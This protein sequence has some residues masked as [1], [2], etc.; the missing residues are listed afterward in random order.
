MEHAGPLLALVTRLREQL[1]QH[2]QQ[3][4]S[5]TPTVALTDA[6]ATVR[7]AEPSSLPAECGEAG[8]LGQALR[9]AALAC[10]A[11]GRQVEVRVL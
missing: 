7:W 10:E 8:L 4:Q 9:A 11:M 2:E 1:L 6:P 5:A 3:Q